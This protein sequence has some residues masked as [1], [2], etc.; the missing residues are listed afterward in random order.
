MKLD[1][2]A[3][4]Q[5]VP[6]INEKYLRRSGPQLIALFSDYGFRDVYGKGF[7][8][9][10][11]YT[12]SRLEKINNTKQLEYLTNFLVNSR[13]YIHSDV[14]VENVKTDVE[15]IIRHCNYKFILNESNE[16]VVTGTGLIQEEKI[17]VEVTFEDIQHNILTQINN[18]QFLIW[19]SVAWFTD[20][21]LYEAL[22]RKATEG[23]NVQLIINNDSINQ[24]TSFNFESHFE[25]YRKDHF[26]YYQNIFH[27]K[28]CIIDLKTV[29]NG[30]YN[31][32]R[33]AQ[34]NRENINTINSYE[35]AA[36]YAQRFINLKKL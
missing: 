13:S 30:S 33:K 19:V 31:W 3:L 5:L 6:V 32:T 28:F 8:S 11:D 27:E 10:K 24:N 25:T 1:K 2:F 22:K 29:I 14:N 36:Q 9:R 21:V 34:Y 17:K 26:G 7:P 16:Y 12:L 18:A 15:N 4:T 20:S 23:I 35:I